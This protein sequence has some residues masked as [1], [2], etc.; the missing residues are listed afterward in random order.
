M[1][2][3]KP[4][5]RRKRIVVKRSTLK[6][7]ADALWAAK[8]KLLKVENDRCELADRH[9]GFPCSGPTQ[10]AHGF[11]RRYLGTRYLPINGFALCRAA[12]VY[13]THRPL[14]WDA[15]LRAEWGETVYEELRQRAL[16]GPSTPLDYRLIADAL[17]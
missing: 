4:L 17:R 10:A 5:K 8:V 13:W 11:S 6:N 9:P 15:V 14:E 1:I 3:T 16:K 12:H 2:R 7:K